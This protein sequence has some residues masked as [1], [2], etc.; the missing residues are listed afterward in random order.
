MALYSKR[1]A[2][3]VMIALSYVA[4]YFVYRPIVFSDMF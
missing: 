3:L 2:L 1:I 4:F